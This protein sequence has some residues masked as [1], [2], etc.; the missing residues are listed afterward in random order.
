MDLYQI[1][2]PDLKMLNLKSGGNRPTYSYDSKEK[3]SKS[4]C[5]KEYNFKNRYNLFKADTEEYLG[6]DTLLGL[7]KS[8]NIDIS[9]LYKTTDSNATCR[10]YTLTELIELPYSLEELYGENYF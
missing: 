3:M 5:N 7:S 8:F 10:E 1:L 6:T 9:T 2:Y 4:K